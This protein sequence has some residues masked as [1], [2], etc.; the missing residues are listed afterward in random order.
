MKNVAH[1]FL[2]G[3]IIELIA[4]VALVT[5]FN[6]ELGFMG[7]LASVAMGLAIPVVDSMAD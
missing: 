4:G 7:I 2:I 6:N 3:S 1:F 5:F